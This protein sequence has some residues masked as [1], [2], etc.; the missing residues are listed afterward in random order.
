MAKLTDLSLEELYARKI[1]PKVEEAILEKDDFSV[2]SENWCSKACRLKNKCPSSS[3]LQ[4]GKVDIL[5]IQ[6]YRAFDDVRFN[7][8]G[9]RI[10]KGLQSITSGLMKRALGEDVRNISFAV[11]TML[12][13]GL[14]RED[15]DKGKAPAD[16]IIQKC[17]PYLLKEI[18][19]RQPK[20]IIS[21][22]TSVTK[23]LVK[24][25]T[26]YANRG[27]ITSYKGVP[28]V[29]T[30][31]PRI[32]TMLRQ[33]SSGKFWGPDFTSVIERDFEKARRIIKG[34]LKVPDL[35]AAIEEAK[36]R[37]HIARSMDDVVRM[38][39]HLYESGKAGKVLS[40]DLE[41]NSLD[42]H[43]PDAKI[44]T[45]QFGVR[46]E[47]GQI[48]AYVIPHKHRAN[49]WFDPEEAWPHVARILEDP[50]I[51]KIGHNIKFDILFTWFTEF[52][53]IRGV[54]Y[55]TMLLLHCGNTGLQGMYGLKQ[56]VVDHLPETE[57]GG[58]EDKLPKLSKIV[59]ED[60]GEGEQE[61]QSD[62]PRGAH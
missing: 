29:I 24:G 28:L 49:I 57:L 35:D 58:Y 47:D 37:I 25:K 1:T 40:Y 53:R 48:H 54:L 15:L 23:V 62:T 13:C 36:K 18:E 22:A 59:D 5:V 26:N 8:S 21:L 60:E 30:L 17:K 44:I 33:N 12:K 41:T 32:L 19:L 52:T 16:T 7:K 56:A 38:T 34:E 11:T 20:V 43:A 31:H 10:E 55:D 2:I 46:E 14:Q 51:Y 6:D 50:E 42:P 3:S 61:E 27:D 45:A 9:F 39:D 4:H